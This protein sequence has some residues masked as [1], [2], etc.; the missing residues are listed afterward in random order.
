MA[1]AVERG[2]AKTGAADK[3]PSR[4]Q[5]AVLDVERAIKFRASSRASSRVNERLRHEQAQ[6]HGAWHGSVKHTIIHTE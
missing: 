5:S 3:P 1:E 6:A 2:W 4:A